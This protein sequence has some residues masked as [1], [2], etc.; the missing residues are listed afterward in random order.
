MSQRQKRKDY[1]EWIHQSFPSCIVLTEQKAIQK[2]LPIVAT[3]MQ[4]QEEEVGQ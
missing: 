4:G 1:L 3:G 2:Q